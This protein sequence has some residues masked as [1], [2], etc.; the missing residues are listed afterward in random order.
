MATSSLRDLESVLAEKARILEAVRERLAAGQRCIIAAD[1][2]RLDEET[3][4]AEEGFNRLNL[5]NES[6]RS[7]L[8]RSGDELGLPDKEQ[9]STIIAALEPE[10][11]SRFQ[12]LQKRCYSVA[13]SIS[14]L[15]TM[16][17]A[18]LKNSLDIVGRSLTL[19]GT[20][21]K[22]EETYGAAGRMTNSGTAAGII[23]REIKI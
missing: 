6:V 13:G 23:C 17:E 22:G 20:F 8:A 9:L 4:K 14:I 10:A 16:N 5:L 3:R 2:K 21:L 1:A 18:L 12:E 19:F 7:I 11:R 15:L